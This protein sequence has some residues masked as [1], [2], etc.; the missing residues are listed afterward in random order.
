MFIGRTVG[1]SSGTVW[2]ILPELTSNMRT[3]QSEQQI[4]KYFPVLDTVIDIAFNE[5]SAKEYK[6]V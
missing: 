2:I 3:D 1:I 6:S 4:A 5:F